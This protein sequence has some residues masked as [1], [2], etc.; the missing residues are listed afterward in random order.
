MEILIPYKRPKFENLCKIV[1]LSNDA[2]SVHTVRSDEPLCHGI[3]FRK[4]MIHAS[5][6]FV[7]TIGHSGKYGHE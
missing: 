5:Q 7:N 1:W 3:I 4:C 2:Y 6:A